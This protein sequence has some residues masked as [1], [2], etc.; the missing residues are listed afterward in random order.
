MKKQFFI[1]LLVL[2]LVGWGFYLTKVFLCKSEIKAIE[3]QTRIEVIDSIQNVLSLKYDSL[4]DVTQTKY[5]SLN[6]L[7]LEKKTK[8]IIRYEKILVGVDT[9]S[10]DD[11]IKLFTKYIP[12]EDSIK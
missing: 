3:R 9:L 12:K 4:M 2:A 7:Y 11:N 1:V 8:T 5:D 6:T 10:V